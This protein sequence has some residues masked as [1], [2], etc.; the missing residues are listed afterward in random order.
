M[1]LYTF[2]K[3]VSNWMAPRLLRFGVSSRHRFFPH[4][5]SY[6]WDFLCGLAVAQRLTSLSVYEQSRG[7]NNRLQVLED[8]VGSALSKTEQWKW[9]IR[10]LK[11]LRQEVLVAKYEPK[12]KVWRSLTIISFVSYPIQ[13]TTLLW[14]RQ[15]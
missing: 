3:Y 14:G 11:W 6:H 7:S 8:H 13:S 2:T 4:S 1:V 10:L 9:N 5:T 15:H 12:V